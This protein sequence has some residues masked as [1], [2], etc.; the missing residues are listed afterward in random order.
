VYILVLP[1][2]GIIRHATMAL[3]G[4][5]EVESYIGI[6]YRIIRIGLIGTVV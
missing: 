5:L 6:V 2:F 1:A 3:T 4:K